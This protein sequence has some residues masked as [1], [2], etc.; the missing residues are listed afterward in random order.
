MIESAAVGWY[1][2]LATSVVGGCGLIMRNL[3]VKTVEKHIE[4][5]ANKL[6]S[7]YQEDLY[8]LRVLRQHYMEAVDCF[9]QLIGKA[10]NACREILEEKD[11]KHMSTSV[12]LIAIEKLET[13]LYKYDLLMEKDAYD[14]IHKFKETCRRFLHICTDA[15]IGDNDAKFIQMESLYTKLNTERSSAIQTLR[16]WTVNLRSLTPSGLLH[17]KLDDSFGGS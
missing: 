7:E 15:E 6:V 14:T 11:I 2:V 5:R 17:P 10:R 12:L 13:T 8:L 1:L 4:L 3:I 9:P 16:E